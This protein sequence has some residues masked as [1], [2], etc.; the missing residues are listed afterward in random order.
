MGISFKEV[1]HYYRGY[2]KKDINIALNNI[3]LDINEK[4]EFIAIVGKTGSGKSTL[5]QHINGLKLPSKGNVNVFDFVLTPKPRK[6]PKLRNVRKR[7]GFVFQFPEYQL[8]EETVLKDIMF[9]PMNF[10]MKK[11]EAKQK[12]IEVAKLLKI[13][14]LLD[15]S[16]FN[17]SGG[18]MRKVAIAGILSYDPDVLLLDEPTRGL[19]PKGQEEIME[20]FYNIHKQTN[21]TIIMITHD[22]DLVYQYANRVVVLNDGVITYD[23]KKEEL[24]NSDIYKNNSLVKPEVLE[25]IDYLNKK[26]NLNIDYNTYTLDDLLKK[27]ENVKAGDI[28]E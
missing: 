5:L 17:L 26:L 6:N 3:S 16:P 27:L 28:N 24:F 25:L 18:Q 10:G 11:E 23:G 15:K 13:E 12:A 1:S 4:N 21:K 20:L 8:F 9:A 2:K 14:D 7:V 22:M 19:D